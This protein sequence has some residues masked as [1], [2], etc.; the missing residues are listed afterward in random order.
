M[1]PQPDD[2]NWILSQAIQSYDALLGKIKTER[3]PEGPFACR[4]GCNTCCSQPELSLSAVELFC[5]AEHIEKNY[6]AGEIEKLHRRLGE[7]KAAKQETAQADPQP[8]YDCPLM[9]EQGCT[10]YDVRPF[11]CRGHHSYDLAEC[12]EAKRSGFS[13]AVIHQYG[14]QVAAA[15]MIVVA[16]RQSLLENDLEADLLDLHLALKIA[17]GNPEARERWL[18]GESVFAEARARNAES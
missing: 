8:L 11:A 12:E 15:Q 16:L 5:I 1:A 3:P 2:L 14:E 4:Q 17:L 13:V 9:T 7:L 10:V 6:A 18:A